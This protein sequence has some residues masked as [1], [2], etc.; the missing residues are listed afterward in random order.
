MPLR[1]IG[2]AIKKYWK[3]SLGMVIALMVATIFKDPAAIDSVLI[4][5]PAIFLLVAVFFA[6]FVPVLEDLDEQRRSNGV[7]DILEDRRPKH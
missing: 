6:A 7:S 1:R 2:R 3:E 4:A 5:S